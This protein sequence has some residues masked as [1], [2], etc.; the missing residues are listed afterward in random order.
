MFDVWKNVLEEIKQQISHEKFVTYL[1]KTSLES[2]ENGDIK[3]G[4]PNIFMK[5]NVK[6]NF[7]TLI[8]QALSHNNISV[9]STE[10]VIVDNNNSHVKKSHEVTSKETPSA[11][12]P[13]A[14]ISNTPVRSS[15][16]TGLVP[17]KYTFSNFVVGTNNDLAF[18]IAKMVVEDPGGKYNPFFLY[19]KSGLGKTHL[20]QAIGNELLRKNP[21]L[22]ILYTP[23]NH[24]YS[25]FV[26]SIQN[27]K[28][29][30]FRKK[31]ENLDV[32]IVDDF[33]LIIG[34]EKSQEEFFNLFNDMHLSGRQI[35]ITS[36]RLPS[37]IKDL[38]PRLASRLTQTGS[39]DIQF[40]SF[41][42]RCAII[43]AKAEFSGK[44][45][46]REAIEYIAENVKTNIRDL[47]SEY[48]K[49]LAFAEFR[50]ITPLEIINSGYNGPATNNSLRRSTTPKKIIDKTAKFYEMDTKT[51]LSKSRV[52]HIKN[53]RQVA[54]YL[55]QNELGLSTTKV[56]REL[57]LKDH[58]TV[59]NGVKRINKELKM[60]FKLR[61]DINALREKIYE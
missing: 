28:Q 53:A 24:F 25:D 50:G 48:E 27:K 55:L 42:D 17:E 30:T 19:G 36:D 47:E 61:E 12:R 43:A 22:K 54:M 34:K 44:E 11:R 20:V 56:A 33:Q 41:E 57:D 31:Y 1:Q 49:L 52:A 3:I 45:I 4:V 8:R 6:K 38:D 15:L 14:K 39:Y 35:I 37:E 18:S 58:T 21:N 60:N 10:Y 32:L 16:S 29:D 9:N 5:T 46:E 7:D 26:N 59:M 2:T 13:L 40:P 51:M 23:I